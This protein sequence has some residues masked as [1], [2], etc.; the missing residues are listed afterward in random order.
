MA[1]SVVNQTEQ[2]GLAHMASMPITKQLM[3]LVGI[4]ASVAMGVYLVLWAQTPTKSLLFGNL[5]SQEMAEVVQFLDSQQIQYDLNTAT[6]TIMVP[7]SRVHQLRLSL[8]GQGIPQSAGT[9]YELLDQE[10]GFGISQFKETT[11]FHRALEGELSRSISSFDTVKHARVHLALPKRSAFFRKREKPSA[12]VVLTLSSGRSLGREQVNAIVH[13]VASSVPDMDANQ[14]SVVDQTG[15]LL[16]ADSNGDADL[17][18]SIKQLEYSKA[19]ENRLRAR[20]LRLL[21]PI[22]GDGQVRAQVNVELDFTR[23]EQTTEDYTPDPRALRSEQRMEELNG[24]KSGPTGAPGALSNQPAAA[25]AAPETGFAGNGTNLQNVD[26]SKAQSTRNYEL[27]R[28][29]SHTKKSVGEIKRLSIAVVID[30]KTSTDAE[31]NTIKTAH[32]EEEIQRYQTL[33]QNAIGFDAE[34]GDSVSVINAAFREVKQEEIPELPIWEQAWFQDLIKQ[35]LG[36]LGLIVL[37]FAVI[38]PLMKAMF[39]GPA[40]NEKNEESEQAPVQEVIEQPQT[41][42]MKLQAN[43]DTVQKLADDSPEAT[44]RILKQFL[45]ED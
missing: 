14:V 30:D 7:A 29:I 26:K 15:T 23:I 21:E 35:V 45:Q 2:T 9:G 41:P 36:V 33:V 24:Q 18:M 44:A 31:G 4:V 16:T 20:V 13:L 19:V 12:S 39:G 34:R 42:E 40:K 17:G 28:T 10:Q 38:R 22:V 37:I 25:G 43:L 27:D 8:A 11:Q 1:D 5:E 32:T 6:G 3:L